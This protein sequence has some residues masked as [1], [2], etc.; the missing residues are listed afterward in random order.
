MFYLRSIT[1]AGVR[2]LLE[3]D[4]G[5]EKHSLDAF[6]K[7][8]KNQIDEVA[9]CYTNFFTSKRSMFVKSFSQFLFTGVS[10]S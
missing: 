5:L 7:F 10:I 2:R 6:K 3:E 8:I 1:L 9:F 4:L